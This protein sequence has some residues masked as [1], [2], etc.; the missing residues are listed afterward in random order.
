MELEKYLKRIGFT[1][2]I[3]LDRVTLDGLIAAHLQAVAF[4]NLDQKMGIPVSNDLE[5]IYRKIVLDGRG[6]WCFELNGLFKWVLQEIG[7]KV[8]TLAGYVGPECPGPEQAPDHM[9]LRV[10]CEGP[11]L[12]DVGFGG[13]PNAP[14]PLTPGVNSQPPY[15]IS[16]TAENGGFFRYAEKAGDEETAYWFKPQAVEPAVFATASHTLQTDPTSPF[17][18]TLTAQRR[19]PDKHVVLRGLVKRTVSPAGCS[20]DILRSK[21][22]FVECLRQDFGLDVPAVAHLFPTL[23]Q[24]HKELFDS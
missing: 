24:R 5:S 8:S 4:E 19:Y 21:T 18:R 15:T 3:R 22:A 9:T 16:L 20:E 6:G 13:G 1:D 12:V 23:E 17:R 7:F 14:V 2:P 11:L 10:E